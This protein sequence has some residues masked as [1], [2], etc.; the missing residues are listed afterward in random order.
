MAISNLVSPG[1][2]MNL[3][4]VSAFFGTQERSANDN[5]QKIS[6]T[7]LSD[8]MVSSVVETLK[9]FTSEI[10]RL[11]E[12]SKN[13]VRSFVGLIKSFKAIN[14]DINIRFKSLSSDITASRLDFV[15]NIMTGVPTAGA[16]GAASL[17]DKFPPIPGA[18]TP[19]PK[20]DDKPG[21]DITEALL[22]ALGLAGTVGKGALV[23]ALGGLIGFIASPA[24]L[25]AAGILAIGAGGYFAY[26][27]LNEMINELVNSKE[28][29]E[30]QERDK[31]KTEE[32]LRQ[33]AANRMRERNDP[34]GR[35][36]GYADR[37]EA[38]KSIL[39]PDG[40]PLEA[41]DVK[42]V[43]KND[44]GEEIIIFQDDIAKR[45][46][47]AALNRVTGERYQSVDSTVVGAFKGTAISST[48]PA[49]ASEAVKSA[50]DTSSSSA[51]GAGEGGAG[52]N[53]VPAGEPVGS[54]TPAPAAPA[55]A[56][57]TG[58]PAPAAPA[59]GGAAPAPAGAP[60]R[61]STGGEPL[62]AST[63][64]HWMLNH[65]DVAAAYAALSS[66]DKKKAAELAASGQDSEARDYVLRRGS[67]PKTLPAQ[68]LTGG[69][70]TVQ[71]LEP[72]GAPSG[73]PTA[74]PA[75][76]APEAP[77][78]TPAP[79]AAGGSAPVVVNN[80][81]SQASESASNTEGNNVAGQNFP[82]FVADPF[83]QSYIQRQTPHYQ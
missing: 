43:T 30:I 16:A 31:D 64:K 5:I 57:P 3:P 38:L 83:V 22:S 54:P 65:P 69:A 56:A 7:M 12:T 55:P 18:P 8:S 61:T 77:P 20:K 37:A 39:K 46:G 59:G 29:K 78:A 24:G 17:E 81:T 50:P 9:A 80:N 1:K 45:V 67:V 25:A 76:T 33:E 66:S 62:G 73:T 15:R 28:F 51:T 27:K 42:S 6:S 79:S 11:Q 71:G 36:M 19:E 32:Q 70:Q 63:A 44:K 82:M 4:G 49:A 48:P 58:A 23:K 60:A 10:G 2:K 34:T 21:F 74:A 47:F 40:K 68:M 52:L 53:V 14:R 35:Q 13:I 72:Q 41:R 75:P 26:K